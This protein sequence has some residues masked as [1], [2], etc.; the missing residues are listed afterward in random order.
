MLRMT[1][2]ALGGARLEV[3][4]TGIGMT[5]SEVVTAMSVFGQV[6]NV[7]SRRHSGTGLGLPLALAFVQL[8]G[9]SLRIESAPH[10]GTRV[11]IEL[12]PSCV[13]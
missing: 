12:P 5:T 8:H 1:P 13:A 11:I 3:I 7:M 9:G 4:D 10:K 6:E 2:G